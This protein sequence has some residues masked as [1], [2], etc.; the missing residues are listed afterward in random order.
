MKTT[1]FGEAK[2][3]VVPALILLLFGPS[4]PATPGRPASGRAY[5]ATTYHVDQRDPESSDDNSG[6]K[7]RPFE[8]IGRAASRVGPGDT[9]IVRGG[10]YRERVKVEKSG[11]GR[12]RE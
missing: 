12:E 3:S 2:T 7:M 8:T 6:T 1:S 10:V 11:A 9:V 4:L 5:A